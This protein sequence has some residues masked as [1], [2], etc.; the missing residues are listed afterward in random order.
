MVLYGKIWQKKSNL[1]TSNY[2]SSKIGQHIFYVLA[3]D[4]L[5]NDNYCLF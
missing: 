1:D 5:Q 3:H 2:N 4:K